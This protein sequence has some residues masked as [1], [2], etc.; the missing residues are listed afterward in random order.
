MLWFVKKECSQELEG[1]KSIGDA[2]HKLNQMVRDDKAI[3]GAKMGKS[4]MGIEFNS[5][6]MNDENYETIIFDFE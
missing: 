5:K 6:M 2:F 3:V 4:T 1:L